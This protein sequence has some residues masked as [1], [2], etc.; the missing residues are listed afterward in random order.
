MSFS[1]SGIINSGSGKITLPSVESWG[2]NMNILRDPPKSYMT[3][4]KSYVGDTSGLTQ[5]VDDSSDRACESITTYARGINPFVSVN[6]A[7]S[8]GSST[9][10]PYTIMKDGAF[11]PPVVAPQSLLPLSRQPRNWTTAFT[12]PGFNDFSKK[13]R[14]CGT[15]EETREVRNS[16]IR[17]S[18]RPSAVFQLEKQPTVP[19]E[20]KYVIQ[21]PVRACANSG[22][23]SMDVTERV[24]KRPTREIDNNNLHVFAQPNCSDSNVYINNYG[25]FNPS[26][27]IQNS[28]YTAA[29]SNLSDS[30]YVNNN[31]E[32]N[33]DKY[34]QDYLTIDA[35]TNVSSSI[36]NVSSIEDIID[37]SEVRVKENMLNSSY[38]V[39][40]QGPQSF[41]Y[42][43]TEPVLNRRMPEYYATTNSGQDIYKSVDYDNQLNLQRK[44]P[45]TSSSIN[46]S[47]QRVNINEEVSSRSY[48]RLPKKIAP[49][50]FYGKAA[51]PLE[52]K[53]NNIKNLPNRKLVLTQREPVFVN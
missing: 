42:I 29:T 45:L 3:S 8:D 48:N 35:N 38:T 39:P 21:N 34:I 16:V 6:Y 36:G 25:D 52:Y 44:T 4:R 53:A 5:M 50:E 13:L 31:G 10:L 20:V 33:T 12:Q 22:V 18:A 37:M 28:L 23:R 2:S 15:A 1:Y 11:R 24:N 14:T 40:A 51:L 17:T 47:S 41:K 26:K 49:G 9:K 43:N 30:K 46:P 19:Y 27:N 32:F 7:N